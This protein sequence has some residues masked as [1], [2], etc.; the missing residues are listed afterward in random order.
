M[1]NLYIKQVFSFSFKNFYLIFSEEADV[2]AYDAT[3]AQDIERVRMESVYGGLA[4]KIHCSDSIFPFQ[5][6]EDIEY[7]K[8]E[9]GPWLEQDDVTFHH[10]R[11]L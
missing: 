1:L 11:M 4:G 3:Q 9:K 2:L 10:M 8:L 7:L 6:V 5:V